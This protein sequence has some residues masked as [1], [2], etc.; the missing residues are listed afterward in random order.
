MFSLHSAL[1]ETSLSLNLKLAISHF[2]Y[3]GQSLNSQSA[4]NPSAG[5][6]HSCTALFSHDAKHQKSGPRE[7]KHFIHLTLSYQT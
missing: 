4:S 6:G 1:F 2:G 3:S 5:S 7:C